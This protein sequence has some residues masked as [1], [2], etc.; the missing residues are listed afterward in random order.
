MATRDILEIYNERL[1]QEGRVEGRSEGSTL[2][3]QEA[4]IDVYTTRF[5]APPASVVT[6]IRRTTDPKVLRGWLK[7]VAGATA[8]EATAA[9]REGRPKVAKPIHG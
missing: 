6:I 5:G 3:Q 9:I 7:L 4:L 2:A 8:Q 1:K